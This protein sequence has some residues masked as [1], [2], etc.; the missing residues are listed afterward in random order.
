MRG[1][2]TL[3]ALVVVCL[4]ASISAQAP[5]PPKEP[6][7][8]VFENGVTSQYSFTTDGVLQL[9]N[10]S[11]WMRTRHVFNDFVLTADVRLADDKT[12]AGI[13]VHTLT[14]A[15]L[16][17]QR[18]YHIR[19]SASA[20]SGAVDARKLDE[21]IESGAPLPQLSANEW[22]SLVVKAE[23]PTVTVMLD[24]H[25]TSVADIHARC[26]SLLFDVRKGRAEFRD[27]VIRSLPYTSHAVEPGPK[28]ESSVK[29]PTLIKEV[30]PSYSAGALTRRIEATVELQAEVL[31]DGT[32]GA[33]WLKK[34]PDPDLEQ[35][36]VAAVA[37][38][39]FNP[40]TADGKPVP[41]L[42]LVQETFT[43]R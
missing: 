13:G 27:I 6:P 7:P 28:D 26:G 22:H 31:E 34:L 9:K 40:G 15:E 29:V 23:G 39:R 24:G 19:L 1:H 16:W 30:K 36:A 21:R 14:T 25:I 5:T 38:W 43:M 35:A 20:P 4:A 11:G 37:Q 18:G 12:D 3:L 41:V 2:G 33:I 8:F 10:G 32:V 42:I 17:P